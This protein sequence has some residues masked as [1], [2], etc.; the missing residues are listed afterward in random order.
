MAIKFLSGQTIDGTLTVSGNV[1]GATFNGL[2][3]NTT[4]VNNVANQI[5]RTEANG[6]VNFGWINSVSG[7]HTGSITRIT[8]SNDAYL[9]Y[10][11]P[12]QFRTGV[13][14]GYYAPVS[15]VSGVTSVATTNGITGGTII[16][17]GTIQ[18]D[19]T[20]IRTTGG[21]TRTGNNVFAATSTATSYDNAAIEIREDNNSGATGTPPHLGFHWGG[22]VASQLTIE[23]NG[24]IA[25]RDNPGTGYED[26]KAKNITAT[27]VVY[28]SGGNSGTWNSHTSNT[29]TV[30]SVTGTGSVSGLTLTGTVT[31][32]GNITLGG[33][34]S[35]FT[36]LNMIRSLGTTAFTNGT[37]PNITTAEVMA[38]IEADGGFDSYSSVFKTSWS[39]AGNYNLTDAGDFTETA[40]SSWITWTDNSSDTTRGNI[41]TLAIAPNTGSSAGGVF[42]YN[43]QGSGYAPGWRQVWTSTT[44]GSGSGLDA[45]LL[46][47]QQGSYYLD[48]NN[49]TNKP[50]IPSVGNG[51]IDGRTSGLGISGSMDATA[52][53]TGNTTFTVTS[54][55]VEAATASTLVYRNS[56]ADINARLFRSNYQTQTTISGAIA[57]RVNTTDNYIRFCNS[58][59]AIRTFLGVPASG[60]LGNYL[61]LAGGTMTG[62]INMG[63]NNITSIGSG[64]S[65]SGYDLTSTVGLNLKVDSGNVSAITI[66]N[67]GSTTFS[68]YT[69]FP[70]YLFHQGDTNT[71]IGFT[72]G[73]V[74]IRGDTSILLDGPVTA[75]S[76]VSVSS[77]LTTN[78]I[79]ANGDINLKSGI[80]LPASSL[81]STSGRPGYKI[82]QEG[83]AWTYPYPDLVIAM[84]TGLKFGANASYE[85]MRF[86]DD[87]TMATQVMSINNGSDP[88]G[89]NN[90]YVNNSLQAGT[91]LR[92]PIFYDSNNTAYYVDPAAASGA[93]AFNTQG[94]IEQINIANSTWPYLFR[95]SGASNSNSSGFWTSNVGYPDMRL[96]RDNGTVRALISSWER[97]YTTNGLNDSTDMR[98]PIFYDLN[99]TAYYLDPASTGTAL[100]IQGAQYI[101]SS[102]SGGNIELDYP[103]GGNTT[104]AGNMVIFM[105]EPGITHD[106]GGI[107]N[108]IAPNSPYYGRKYNHGYGV[109]LRFYKTSGAF[110]FWNTQ[111]TA[112]TAGGQ[113]TKRFWGDVSGNTYSSSSSRAPIFYD[114][115]DTAYYGNFA[116]TSQLNVLNCAGTLTVTGAGG[117]VAPKFTDYNNGAYYLDPAS[118]GT[119]LNVAGDVVAYA[120]SDIRFKNNVLPITNALDKI[121]KIGGYTF[122]WNEKSHKETGKKDIGVIAQEV[123]EILPEI[124]DTRDNGYKAVDYSKLTTL[125]IQ[126]VKEQQVI[127]DNLKSRIETLENN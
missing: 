71:R 108:N 123:E 37:N 85:G 34:I 119:S 102:H 78:A 58:P 126:S 43:D 124:V 49:F 73:T 115:N 69:Y 103:Y 61:P 52:N 77:T 83:G 84:H 109:Y 28:A 89:A 96:R 54:N 70:N 6:Y 15:T 101:L 2:A 116:S 99:N 65:L 81:G 66:D 10:V 25:V 40:G 47:A 3:I 29:G 60:D 76:T 67:V 11:T 35:G 45:D 57:Y 114:S 88:L 33:A 110:E 120:S 36:E 32:T 24:T 42:I 55:A 27:G 106:G 100:K 14:D 111:G 64:L 86:Y 18:V 59:S 121:N 5:V 112:G 12:A 17:T 50:T 94:D 31:S 90:V 41:T 91:S 16:S 63:S 118:T 82:Y 19:S 105:S 7:N 38:E 107:G 8:A 1:Q 74:T 87:Y 117:V 113:G 75:N 46:D 92:A 4:G 125:L 53:Q 80:Q 127:I 62:S 93:I 56:S 9:R 95:T 98:A 104:L 122:E 68:G 72:S 21:Q 51:Q 44:D 48:W 79:Q 30:T 22:V 39:Y 23:S 20:V 13:T 26:F 97:S